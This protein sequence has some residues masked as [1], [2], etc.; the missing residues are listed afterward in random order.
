MRQGSDVGRVRR[1]GLDR[2]HMCTHRYIG[3]LHTVVARTG[4]V[5]QHVFLVGW[6]I[7]G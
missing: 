6:H 7:F 2:Q 4:V 1:V 3:D 5:R